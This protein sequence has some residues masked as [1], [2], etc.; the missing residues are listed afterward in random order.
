MKIIRALGFSLLALTGC[1]S[2]GATE[3]VPSEPLNET[4]VVSATVVRANN[5]VHP[6]CT[7]T[8]ASHSKIIEPGT[9]SSMEEWS[10]T[11]GGATRSYQVLIARI[12]GGVT[13]DVIENELIMLPPTA[14]ECAELRRMLKQAESSN[15]APTSD[16]IAAHQQVM[17]KK[18][19]CQ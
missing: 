11:C 5:S 1:A 2:T 9:H 14:S 3:P 17:Y 18:L 10:V 19:S 13:A 4:A 8:S 15:Q 12:G 6:E 16:L 7:A